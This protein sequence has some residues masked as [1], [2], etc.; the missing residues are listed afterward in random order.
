[1]RAL[2]VPVLL[3]VLLAGA[4]D[5]GTDDD[6]TRREGASTPTVAT[7]AT[8]PARD[9]SPLAGD[10]PDIVERVAPSVVTIGVGQGLGSGVIYDDEGTIVTNAHVVGSASTVEVR[11]ASG[12]ELDGKVVGRDTCTDLAV[13]DVDRRGLPTAEFADRLPRVGALAIAIGSPLGFTN[14]VT[15]GIVSAL[16]REIPSGGASLIDLIQTD[17]PISPGNSGGALV[18]GGGQV[19]GINVAYIPPEARAVAIGFAIPSG[20]AIGVVRE[21]VERGEVRHAFLGVTPQQV[22]DDL[23]EQ[24][25]LGVE[26]GALVVEVSEGTAATRAGIRPGDVVVEFGG[27]RVRLVEDLLAGLRARDP[28][29]RV[30]VAVVRDGE[31][32]ELDV[33][34]GERQEGC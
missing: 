32:R 20:T 12:E 15:A 31:R 24:F 9:G 11:L 18:D 2:V 22:T 30:T 21:L 26:D 28:G 29:D 14:T 25:D 8:T 13:V 34:L 19:I 4:C 16:G 27:E 3:L 33:T 5:A 1:M 17:A 23:A 6:Q 10:I 7:G